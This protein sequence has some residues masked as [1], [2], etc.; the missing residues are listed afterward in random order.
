M[1]V[2]MHCEELLPLLLLGQVIRLLFK[3]FLVTQIYKWQQGMY[4][5]FQNKPIE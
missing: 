2:S 3:G 4:S 5:M 1:R